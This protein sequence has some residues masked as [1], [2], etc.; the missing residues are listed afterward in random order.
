MKILSRQITQTMSKA[1]IRFI[2]NPPRDEP[3]YDTFSKN[4]ETLT[5]Y[6]DYQG[7]LD[8]LTKKELKQMLLMHIAAGAT[9]A[10]EK[11]ALS[12]E[13]ARL[14]RSNAVTLKELTALR[15]IFGYD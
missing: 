1:Y 3:A 4:M 9:F 8:K 11:E 13:N 7:D 2:N 10:A 5:S 14:R 12:D 6:E 15:E